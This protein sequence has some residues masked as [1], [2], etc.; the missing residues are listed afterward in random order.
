MA[1]KRNG[2]IKDNNDIK[3]TIYSLESFLNKLSSEVYY[4]IDKLECWIEPDSKRKVFKKIIHM[5]CVIVNKY[6]KDFDKTLHWGFIKQN[7][8]DDELK[9]KISFQKFKINNDDRLKYHNKYIRTF[10][11]ENKFHQFVHNYEFKVP[12]T[13]EGK[14]IVFEL[15]VN[16]DVP[17]EDLYHSWKVSAPCRRMDHH[18]NLNGDEASQWCMSVIGFAPKVWETNSYDA[19]ESIDCSCGINSTDWVIQEQVTRYF[20]QERIHYKNIY[21]IKY[22]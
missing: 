12:L 13:K 2:E 11:K 22:I 19:S 3:D 18:I 9:N 16:Y 21:Y 5:K 4:D 6:D 17:I 8:T 7:L 10:K 1:G 15:D 14:R 20:Y